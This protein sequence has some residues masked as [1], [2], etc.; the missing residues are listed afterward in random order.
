MKLIISLYLR[1]KSVLVKKN[2]KE[3]KVKVNKTNL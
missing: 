3:I 2:G 1:F